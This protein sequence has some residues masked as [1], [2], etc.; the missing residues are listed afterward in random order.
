MGKLKDFLFNVKTLGDKESA[1]IEFD[2]NYTFML[3]CGKWKGETGSEVRG[4]SRFIWDNSDER[5]YKNAVLWAHKIE[6]RAHYFAGADGILK[7]KGKR[8]AP[9][10]LWNVPVFTHILSKLGKA[11]SRPYDEVSTEPLDMLPKTFHDY[12]KEHKEPV[13]FQK[14]IERECGNY[15]HGKPY[16]ARTVSASELYAANVFLQAAMNNGVVA[17]VSAQ[18]ASAAK[19]VKS[20][21]R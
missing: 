11:P 9:I 3:A 8:G 1:D 15:D 6:G 2:D 20:V 13:A 10:D 17:D 14:I 16:F 4:K 18:P 19:P 7:F 12:T 21:A 5:D